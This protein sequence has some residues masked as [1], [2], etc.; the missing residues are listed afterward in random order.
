MV[1]RI[2]QDFK[3]TVNFIGTKTGIN[4][5]GDFIKQFHLEAMCKVSVR[6]FMLD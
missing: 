6:L 1:F 4:S 5:I 2:R 3:R